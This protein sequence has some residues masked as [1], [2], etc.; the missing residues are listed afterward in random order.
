[1]YATKS[2]NQIFEQNKV[3]KIHPS[4]DPKGLKFR[5]CR[6]SEVHPQALPII[7]AL[8]V[9]GSMGRIP[10]QLIQEGLPTLMSNLI[11][12]GVPHAAVCFIAVGDHKCDRA[13]LQ[14]AQFESG[15]AELDMYL[16]RTWL[17]GNGGGNGGESYSIAYYFAA[18][19]TVSDAWE[20]RKHKGFLFTIGDEAIHPSIPA[21][22]L[23]EI[24]GDGEEISESVM[25]EDI[26]KAA[27]EKFNCF[28]LALS[29]D[30]HGQWRQLLGEAYLPI[31]DYTLIPN[32]IADKVVEMEGKNSTVE[33]V[34]PG[35][36]PTPAK[37][38]EML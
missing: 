8:D 18:K 12:H 38:E 2:V 5:E 23:K 31:G 17:E 16:E 27:Q 34:M 7:I 9:T 22:A 15:D 14:C 24:F 37:D 36:T 29:G 10:Y 30:G 3:A 35:N 19:H 28:H 33:T 11:E 21:S 4:M 32:F 25:T 26:L 20:K 6:D 13:P 1:M